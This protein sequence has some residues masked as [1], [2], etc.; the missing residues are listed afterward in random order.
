MVYSYDNMV[1]GLWVKNRVVKILSTLYRISYVVMSN[2]DRLKLHTDWVPVAGEV[3]VI[4]NKKN[5]IFN[6]KILMPLYRKFLKPQQISNRS[7]VIYV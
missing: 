2:W 5:I 7:S 1:W 4:Y 3:G 6:L